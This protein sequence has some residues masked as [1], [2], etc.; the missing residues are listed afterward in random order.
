MF[1]RKPNEPEKPEF[2]DLAA[3]RAARPPVEQPTRAPANPLTRYLGLPHRP[4]LPSIDLAHEFDDQLAKLLAEASTADGDAVHALAEWEA[5]QPAGSGFGAVV[6]Q[7]DE[8][9]KPFIQRGE[10]A[11]I[12]GPLYDWLTRGQHEV[13]VAAVHVRMSAEHAD[14]VVREYAATKALRDRLDEASDLIQDQ[15]RLLLVECRD[16]KSQRAY[17]HAG[18]LCP[19]WNRAA[20]LHEWA[21]NP[22]VAYRHRN[23][24]AWPEALD[25]EEFEAATIG[26]GESRALV[27]DRLTGMPQFIHTPGAKSRDSGDIH[28]GPEGPPG[29]RR[30]PPVS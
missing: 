22:T 28:W 21:M 11:P 26:L 15:I 23:P 3:L 24:K 19:Q 27:P 2:V 7:D 29:S 16:T 17:D 25:V 4:G 5:Y 9:V 13:F 30:A 18:D 12:A 8:W 6:A 10:E 1:G 20:S 14:R